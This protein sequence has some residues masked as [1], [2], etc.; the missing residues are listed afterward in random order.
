LHRGAAFGET[1]QRYKKRQLEPAAGMASIIAH[2]LP[3]GK[4]APP[5]LAHIVHKR[6]VQH[7]LAVRAHWTDGTVA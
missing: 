5:R 6:L 2:C 3:P 7:R 1:P 4:A